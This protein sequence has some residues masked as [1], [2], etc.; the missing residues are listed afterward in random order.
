MLSRRL[1]GRRDA[2]TPIHTTG[3]I[4]YP[5]GT[6]CVYNVLSAPRSRRAASAAA[7]APARGTELHR[8]GDRYGAT[9]RALGVSIR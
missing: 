4:L 2:P 5:M 3:A 6:R 9:G 8:T 7:R 1:W